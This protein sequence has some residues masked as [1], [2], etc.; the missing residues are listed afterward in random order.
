[1]DRPSG[2]LG[3]TN[4]TGN[5]KTPNEPDPQQSENEGGTS[6]AETFAN[7]EPDGGESFANI[8][9]DKE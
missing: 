2:I 9:P 6:E 3:D 4:M 8:E 7:I 5:G 1:M